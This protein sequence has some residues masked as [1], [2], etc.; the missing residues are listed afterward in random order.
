MV[1]QMVQLKYKKQQARNMGTIIVEEVPTIPRLDV[2]MLRPRE[3]PVAKLDS[4]LL[5]SSFQS[6][7]KEIHY[8][9]SKKMWWIKS[10][11]SHERSTSPLWSCLW[12]LVQSQTHMI[13]HD[14][15]PH[16]TPLY[17]IVHTSYLWNSCLPTTRKS[18][19]HHQQ[20]YGESNPSFP[21]NNL[22]A[23]S[24]PAPTNGFKSK[25]TWYDPLFH[26]HHALHTAGWGY[27][28]SHKIAGHCIAPVCLR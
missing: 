11:I 14:T 21:G 23:L 26:L 4:F 27:G 24:D 9:S 3:W 20:R 12:Q 16:I 17:C 25:H 8:P 5:L 13:R 6:M 15:I 28:V 19:I 7:H 18:I 22:P 10:K 1:A 2:E